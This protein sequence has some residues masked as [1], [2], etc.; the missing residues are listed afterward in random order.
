MVLASVPGRR[1]DMDG[2]P[3]VFM[4]AMAAGLPVV[5]SRLSGIP[6]LVEDRVTGYLTEP[7]DQAGLAEALGQ[8]ADNGELRAR[9][10][11]AGRRK[12]EAEFDLHAN[13]DALAGL[14]L[15]R[16]A[17]HPCSGRETP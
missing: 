9:M 13:A 12:V 3:V 1:G 16:M 2:I 4:E 11:R 10:G 17:N 8:L 14:F 7:G 5:G 15:E 6:E